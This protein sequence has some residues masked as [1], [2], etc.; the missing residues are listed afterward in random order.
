M[1]PRKKDFLPPPAAVAEW[2]YGRVELERIDERFAVELIANGGYGF[3]IVI[4]R[5]ALVGLR[6]RVD[7]LLA[8]EPEAAS[9]AASIE[10]RENR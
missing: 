3:T 9:H 6:G 7:G 10:R 2:H 5:D 4:D 1:T 8:G